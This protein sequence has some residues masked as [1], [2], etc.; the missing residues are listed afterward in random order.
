MDIIKPIISIDKY[1]KYYVKLEFKLNDY[2]IRNKNISLVIPSFGES[3]INEI[4]DIHDSTIK[5]QLKSSGKGIYNNF[6]INKYFCKK[7]N[8]QIKY[9]STCIKI[10]LIIFSGDKTINKTEIHLLYLKKFDTFDEHGIF[11]QINNCDDHEYNYKI[12]GFDSYYIN[13]TKF[14]K[15]RHMIFGCT[16]IKAIGDIDENTCFEE[17]FN[18]IIYLCYTCA[19]IKIKRHND[20]IKIIMKIDDD[21]ILHDLIIYK[22]LTQI[23]SIRGISQND[24]LFIY[25]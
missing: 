25:K 24:P 9:K 20:Q 14:L 3:K 19:T 6:Y 8:K 7:D 1:N 23:C 5:Y 18:K 21:C 10:P 12:C 16:V 15:N 22:I 17:I 2:D 4:F 11:L 13:E